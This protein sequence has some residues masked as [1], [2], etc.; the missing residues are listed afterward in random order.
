[1]VPLAANDRT[2]KEDIPLVELG[3]AVKLVH[4]LGRELVLGI[5]KGLGLLAMGVLKPAVRV[6]NRGA[7]LGIGEVGAADLRVGNLAVQG[8]CASVGV[9]HGLR[10]CG[11][12]VGSRGGES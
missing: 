9:N 2:K 7:V 4:V 1:M 5:D 6:G 8:C 3:L 11:C 12:V 10:K